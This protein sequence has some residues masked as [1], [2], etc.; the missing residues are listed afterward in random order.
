MK[1]EK[2]D[3]S[4][5]ANYKDL[6]DLYIP[7]IRI[8]IVIDLLNNLKELNKLRKTFLREFNKI[9]SGGACSS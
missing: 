9:L 7:Y 2:Y 5:K 8:V 4:I 3:S 1:T 6:Y